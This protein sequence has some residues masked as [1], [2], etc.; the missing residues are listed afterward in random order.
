MSDYSAL[1]ATID[2]N[3]TDNGGGAITGPVLNAV[4]NEMVD[5]LGDSLVT[6]FL[7]YDSI[8]DLPTVGEK[9]V[10]YL[11]DGHL[12]LYVGTGGD[13]K[14]GTYQDCGEFKG[15]EGVGFA[16][17]STNQDGTFIITLTNGNTITIDL[18]HDHTAYPKYQRCATEADY[19]ALSTHDNNTLYL[20]PESS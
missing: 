6:G 12:Y 11:V 14:W 2:A 9:Y 16:S 15:E 3:I 20:I 13:T 5:I 4:L 10:G 1:K 8:E 19:N 17:V 7:T 18:N